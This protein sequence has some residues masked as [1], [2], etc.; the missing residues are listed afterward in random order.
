[1]YPLLEIESMKDEELEQRISELSK[2]YFQTQN[3]GLKS[4]VANVLDM[5]RIEM[6]TRMAKKYQ[7]SNEDPE[8]DIDNLINIT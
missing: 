8:K 7:E 1:M 5:L 4:Q 3:P 6:Q 2:K